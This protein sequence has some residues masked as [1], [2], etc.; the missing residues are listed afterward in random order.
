[1]VTALAM[2]HAAIQQTGVHTVDGVHLERFATNSPEVDLPGF[3]W[4]LP[5]YEYVEDKMPIDI[6]AGS[7]KMRSLLEEGEFLKIRSETLVES[8]DC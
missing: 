7:D 3:A 8:V 2:I 1:V 6:L 5:P 4:K